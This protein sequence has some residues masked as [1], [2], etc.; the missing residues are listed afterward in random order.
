MR[1]LRRS[2]KGPGSSA[3]LS[4]L[5]CSPSFRREQHDGA[6]SLLEDEG[7]ANEQ[8]RPDGQ[9]DADQLA[10]PDYRINTSWAGGGTD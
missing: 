2:L 3:R 4:S 10:A 1:G 8:A 7:A 5:S 9:Q 6:A